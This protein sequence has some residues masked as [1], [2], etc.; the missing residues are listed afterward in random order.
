MT[1][2]ASRP[3]RYFGQWDGESHQTCH[4]YRLPLGGTADNQVTRTGR[5]LPWRRVFHCPHLCTALAPAR[6]FVAKNGIPLN[7]MAERDVPLLR[8]PAC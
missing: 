1:G 6:Q 8:L 5:F 7:T 2:E 3:R 4:K